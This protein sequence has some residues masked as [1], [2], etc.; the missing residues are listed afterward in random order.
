MNLLEGAA[1]LSIAGEA[2]PI[3][4]PLDELQDEEVEL[5]PIF[6]AAGS[7]DAA[8]ATVSPELREAIARR[9][10]VPCVF[11]RGPSGLIWPS[12]LNKQTAPRLM[13]VYA[14]AVQAARADAAATADGFAN[15]L[16]WYVGARYPVRVRGA[17]RSSAAAT[18]AALD[19]LSPIDRAVAG[20][21]QAILRSKEL[22]ALRAAHAASRSAEVVI[23]GR[24][25]LYEPSLN[26]SGFTLF[27]ENGFVLGRTAFESTPELTKTLLHELHRLATSLSKAEGVTGALAREETAAAASFADALY[28][29]GLRLGLW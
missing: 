2:E 23:N 8:W 7:R 20:E 27:Q 29:K 24:T 14:K 21:A 3:E 4:V 5:L 16:L 9:G 11:F 22:A 17:A 10:M 19:S 15:L 26:A 25:V 1:F 28:A 18:T 12:L 13:V 6:P